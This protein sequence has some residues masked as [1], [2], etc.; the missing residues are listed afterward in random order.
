MAK[1]TCTCHSPQESV[2]LSEGFYKLKFATTGF[3]YFAG[4]GPLARRWAREVMQYHAFN[5]Q[6]WP[7]MVLTGLKDRELSWF[8]L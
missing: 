1:P 6:D 5:S 8:G 4:L 7:L 2:V 3:A